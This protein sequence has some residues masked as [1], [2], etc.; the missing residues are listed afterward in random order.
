MPHRVSIPVSLD[1]A[2][3]LTVPELCLGETRPAS[4]ASLRELEQAFAPG[5]DDGEGIDWFELLTR[6]AYAC[7]HAGGHE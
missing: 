2:W 3:V 4:P 1:L 6:Y 5:D 7:D